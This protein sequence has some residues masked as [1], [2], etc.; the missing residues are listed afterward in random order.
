MS[1][2]CGRRVWRVPGGR[3]DGFLDQ[4]H[5]VAFDM[6]EIKEASACAFAPEQLLQ[7]SL[8]PAGQS[9]AR[10]QLMG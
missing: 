5:T 2:W 9:A 4:Q 1:T 7:Q 10:N 6:I 3:L 8:S